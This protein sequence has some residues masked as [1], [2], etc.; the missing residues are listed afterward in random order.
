MK[1][2]ILDRDG[3]INEDSPDYIKLPDEW[4]PITGSLEAIAKLNQAGYTVVVATNQ[5]GI[6][7]GY[8][9]LETLQKIHQKMHQELK[10]VGGKIDKIYFCPHTPDDNCDCRKPKT[11]LFKQIAQDYKID[12]KDAINIGDTLRDIQAGE[13]FGCRNI[14]VLTGKGKKTLQNNPEIKAEIFPGLASAIDALLDR[15]PA[16]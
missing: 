2:I 3:V 10:K 11:G 6:G 14:L 15:H 4:H 1:L 13:A 7:R 9:S 12:L 5:S 8:F 16:A